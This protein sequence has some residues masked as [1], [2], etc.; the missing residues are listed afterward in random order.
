MV[1]QYNV[2]VKVLDETK[3]YLIELSLKGYKIFTN[4]S[5]NLEATCLSRENMPYV[6]ELIV[7]KT[8]KQGAAQKAY[9]VLS[10][11]EG[12]LV[13]PIS[14]CSWEEDRERIDKEDK[15]RTNKIIK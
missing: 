4:R 3:R 1:I 10:G 7:M 12:L 6:G 11:I 8:L 2:P 14:Q 15:E 5:G 13:M 9:E